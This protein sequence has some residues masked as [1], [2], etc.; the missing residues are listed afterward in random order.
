M[1]LQHYYLICITRSDGNC[2]FHSIAYFDREEEER[3][4]RE[5][6][7]AAAAV[8]QRRRTRRQSLPEEPPL[9]GEGVCTVRCVA[10]WP[11]VLE[12]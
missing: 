8:A 12:W 9:G 2:L 10:L 3:R 4:A 5:E 7:E 6:A 11:V 1:L